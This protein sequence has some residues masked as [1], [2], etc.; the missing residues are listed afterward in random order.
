MLFKVYVDKVK[1]L[2]IIAY[3]FIIYLSIVNGLWTFFILLVIRI[4]IAIP[5]SGFNGAISL[6][7]KKFIMVYMFM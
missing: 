4:F 2:F 5:L 1:L 7:F 3:S 6:L